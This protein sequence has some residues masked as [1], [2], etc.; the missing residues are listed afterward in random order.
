MEPDL[1]SHSWMGLDEGVLRA[2]IFLSVMLGLAVCELVFPRRA[3][4]VSRS[5]RW[6]SNLSLVVLSA[7]V[8]RLVPPGGAVA[9]A[10]IAQSAGLGILHHVQFPEWIELFL[11]VVLLDLTVYLQHRLFHAVPVLWRFHR[12]HHADT[13]FDVTTG[14]RFHPGEILF[15]LGIKCA[16]IT[17]LGPSPLAVLAFEILLNASSMFSHANLKLPTNLDR[18]L[19]CMIVTPD[20]HRVHHSVVVAETNSNFGFNLSCWDWLFRTYRS[21]PEAGHD[22]MQI[23]L[24]EFRHPRELKLGNLLTQPFRTKD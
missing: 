1:K 3:L 18:A 12:V 10:L 8:V 6:P 15:S 23:G 13:E 17:L 11:A 20:M 21:Q 2:S 5:A 24:D 22:A 4:L 9:F 7:L 14:T 16:A 19:R